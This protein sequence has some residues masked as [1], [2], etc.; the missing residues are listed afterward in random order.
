MITTSTTT[1]S[2]VTTELQQL[3]ID[4]DNMS[5][6]GTDISEGEEARLLRPVGQEQPPIPENPQP[7]MCG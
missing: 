2:A 4:V 5:V 7:V 1:F 3:D 6:S